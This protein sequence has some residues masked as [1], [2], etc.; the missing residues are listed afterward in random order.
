[1]IEGTKFSVLNVFQETW[2]WQKLLQSWWK[3]SP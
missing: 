3:Q 1:M 2:Y